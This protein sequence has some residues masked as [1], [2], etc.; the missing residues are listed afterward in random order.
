M[1]VKGRYAH[2]AQ[3]AQSPEGQVAA[4][5]LDRLAQ[6]A[7]GILS[8]GLV[9]IPSGPQVFVQLTVGSTAG[10]GYLSFRVVLHII[11][12]AAPPAPPVAPPL[13]APPVPVPGVPAWPPVPSEPGLLLLVSEHPTPK[14]SATLRINVET[15]VRMAFLLAT[16]ATWK[17]RGRTEIIGGWHP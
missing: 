5:L 9:P 11:K 3:R 7:A 16:G 13:V 6:V 4:Q 8:Q 17:W 12:F 2:F 10:H 14:V 1:P 15:V